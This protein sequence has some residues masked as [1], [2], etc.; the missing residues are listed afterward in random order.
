MHVDITH[1]VDNQTPGNYTVTYTA[2]DEAGNIQTEYLTIVI[3]DPDYE[4]VLTD[5]YATATGLN[6]EALLLEL[7]SIIQTGFTAVSYGDS[8][9]ILDETDQ[10][11]LNPNNVILVYLGTSVSG[12]WDGGTTWNREHVWPQYYL[13][14][15][16]T[17]SSKHVGADLHNLKPANPSEN[18]SRSNR[19]YDNVAIGG[20]SYLPR[21]EVR[22]DVARIL[23]YMIVMYDYLSLVNQAPVIYQMA[24]L[25]VLI[26]WHIDDPVD[27]FERNRNEVIFSYQKNRNPFI[28][29]P[30]FVGMI[31]FTVHMND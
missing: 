21:A 7:R 3:Y 26:Q 31:D 10:D 24:M 25:D 12:I 1:A 17:N 29:Y 9:Y 27:D 28:D 11:P 4:L 8:R 18:S 22:G 23:F 16:T 6:G 14:V 19:Y 30:E 2:T 5:Y 13:D 20:L 15:D